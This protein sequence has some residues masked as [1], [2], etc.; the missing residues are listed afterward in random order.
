MLVFLIKCRVFF[1]LQT[2]A[3]GHYSKKK[4][5]LNYFLL[6]VVVI[7]K[8]VLIIVEILKEIIECRRIIN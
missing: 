4:R 8:K 2:I 6:D 1:V 3:L 5:I 7:V